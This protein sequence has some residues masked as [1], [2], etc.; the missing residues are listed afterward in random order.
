MS[1]VL[2]YHSVLAAIAS[3]N[4][5][6]GGIA[7]YVGRKAADIGHPLTVLEGSQL[8][9]READPLRAGRSYYRICEPLNGGAGFDDA[10][11]GAAAADPLVQ[12]VGLAELY[13]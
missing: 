7:G 8:I 9:V 5:T 11:R 13:R 10:L 12:L 4:A 6:R 3:G 1:F 2:I